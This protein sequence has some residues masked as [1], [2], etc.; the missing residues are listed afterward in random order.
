[1]VRDRYGFQGRHDRAMQADPIRGAP[2]DDKEQRPHDQAETNR[3]RHLR[4]AGPGKGD[5]LLREIHGFDPGRARKGPRLSGHQDRPA[6]DPAQQGRS[7]AL[8]QTVVRGRAQFRFRRSGAASLPRMACAASCATIPFPAWARCCRSRTTRAPP[9][10]CSRNGA[11][12]ASTSRSPASGRSS[13]GTSPSSRRTSNAPSAFYEKVLGFR[14][15]D[16]IG[17][18]FCSCAATPTITP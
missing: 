7:G 17:D 13:S 4:D 16:W 8:H 12:S 5:R 9:S 14:V 10:S 3:T 15:S 6:G 11:I 2:E 1:M 18:F